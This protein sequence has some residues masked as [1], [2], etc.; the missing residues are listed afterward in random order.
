MYGTVPSSRR[1]RKG[2]AGAR[3]G[4]VELAVVIGPCCPG[5]SAILICPG[6]RDVSFVITTQY[7]HMPGWLLRIFPSSLKRFLCPGGGLI[8]FCL[9]L[10]LSKN[11]VGLVT[12]IIRII[13]KVSFE[14]QTLREYES[15]G[16]NMIGSRVP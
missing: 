11:L 4:T 13:I 3:Y 6:G 12:N 9:P 1:M 15:K 8:S 14:D 10:P 2:Y 5:V 16:S 7:V